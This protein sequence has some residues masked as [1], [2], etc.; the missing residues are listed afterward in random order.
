MSEGERSQGLS[1]GVWMGI[2]IL[3]VFLVGGCLLAC[4][5]FLGL[6][7]ALPAVQRARQAEQ[8]EANARQ[9]VEAAAEQAAE[10]GAR[11]AESPDTKSDEG[12]LDQKSTEA[13]QQETP[14]KDRPDDE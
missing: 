6:G 8:A 4:L 2:G 3:G 10:D 1:S 12:P 5:G 11:A 7:F 14:A 9:A 13:E